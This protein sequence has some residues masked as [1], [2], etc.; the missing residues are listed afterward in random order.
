MTRATYTPETQVVR[1]G[2]WMRIQSN[3]ILKVLDQVPLKNTGNNPI[4]TV[5]R[6][7]QG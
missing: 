2:R 1:K 5:G 4:V 6:N 7:K 3:K